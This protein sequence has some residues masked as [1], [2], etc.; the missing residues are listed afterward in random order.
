MKRLL[1]GLLMFS[2]CALAH[3]ERGASRASVGADKGI[4]EAHADEGFILRPS[5]E[6]NFSIQTIVLPAG[7]QWQVPRAALV[8]SGLATQVFR[9]RE[10]HWKSVAVVISKKTTSEAVIRS[11]ELKAGD[12]LAIAG[13][14]FLK[15]IEQSLFVEH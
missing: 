7:L 4:I 12:G 10:G 15:T 9:Q 2:P 8:S 6:Q 11:A 13:T 5:A 14:G 3:E 1:I